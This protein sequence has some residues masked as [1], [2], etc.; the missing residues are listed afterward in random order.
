MAQVFS[1]NTDL[2]AY[3]GRLQQTLEDRGSRDLAEV[4]RR[5][6]QFASGMSAEFL[7]ESRIALRTV[8]Q[9]RNN[10]LDQSERQVLA[11]AILELDVALDR[12]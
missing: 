5:A 10:P 2:Y 11:Q 1:V 3:L 7:G 4:V 6:L 12:K 8:S 9:A